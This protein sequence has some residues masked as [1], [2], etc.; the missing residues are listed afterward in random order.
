VETKHLE[1]QFLIYISRQRCR[2]FT[3]FKAIPTPSSS[4]L[5][6]NNYDR[7]DPRAYAEPLRNMYPKSKARVFQDP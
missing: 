1:F 7:I 5:F 3:C 6:S 4:A 2:N